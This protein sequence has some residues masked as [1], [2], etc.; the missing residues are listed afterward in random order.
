MPISATTIRHGYVYE[1]RRINTDRRYIGSTIS[2]VQRWQQ[3]KSSLRKGSHHSV[4]LQAAW[5]K[6]GEEAFEFTILECVLSE[7]NMLDREQV[8]LDSKPRYNTSFHAK[9]TRLG[10]KSSPEHI[11]RM[12]ASLKGRK[13]INL[14]KKFNQE[15]R[16]KISKALSGKKRRSGWHHSPEAIA[17]MT[18]A[19][20]ANPKRPKTEQ[21]RINQSIGIK[22]QYASL[23]VEERELRRQALI[24]HRKVQCIQCKLLFDVHGSKYIPKCCSPECLSHRRRDALQCRRDLNP[25]MDSESS[26]ARWQSVG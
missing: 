24:I 25:N 18:I 13:G 12:S 19:R 9:A 11:A 6:Y 7:H 21:H 3:H 22:K 5:N 16:D 20:N 4:V 17:K 2:P 10:M 26:K 14:G 1:I 23:S 8:Y 15:H